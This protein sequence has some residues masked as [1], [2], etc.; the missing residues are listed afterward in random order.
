MHGRTARKQNINFNSVKYDT[1][2]YS[3]P[4]LYMVSLVPR[5]NALAREITARARGKLYLTEA[6]GVRYLFQLQLL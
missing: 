6:V 4:L 1:N 3:F 2:A 5:R